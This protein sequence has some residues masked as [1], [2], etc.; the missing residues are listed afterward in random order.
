VLR[1]YFFKG[2][3]LSAHTAADLQAVQ[4]RLNTRPRKTLAWRTPEET[5]GTEMA[6]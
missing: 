3:D 6:S 1:Q 2:G 5:F 4:D